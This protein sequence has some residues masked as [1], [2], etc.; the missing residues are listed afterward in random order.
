MTSVNSKNLDLNVVEKNDLTFVIMNAPT[1][2]NIFAYI[3]ELQQLG[4]AT[5]V[6]V[7]EPTYSKDRCV[8]NKIDVKDHPFEDGAAP[9]QEI[10]E[11][12]LDTVDEERKKRKG[13]C[14]TLCCGA[15]KGPCSC[16]NRFG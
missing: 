8:E 12:W 14:C 15:R 13:R 7:C 10:I 5:I 1:D 6:R 11:T 2:A 3:K 4:V 9:P 16:C